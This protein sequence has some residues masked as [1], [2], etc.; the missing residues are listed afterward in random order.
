V[1]TAS[2]PAEALVAADGQP[3]KGGIIATAGG[4]SPGTRP[5][6]LSAS[7]SVISRYLLDLLVVGAAYF[8]LA[9]L[10][11]TLASINPS[12]TPIWPP[13]GLAL[14]AV[15]LRGYRVWPAIFLAAFAANESTAGSVY[16]S[17]AIALGNTFECLVGGYLTR[18]WSEGSGPFDRPLAVARF[19]LIS[20]VA[21]T[22][23]SATIGVASLSL[24][25]YADT[26]RLASIW[27]TWWLGDLAGALVIT[28][29]I[30][31]WIERLRRP[32]DRHL[33]EAAA[34][35]ALAIVIGIVAF[36]PLIPQ[37]AARDPL[38]FL[39]VVPLMWA[40]LRCG[41]RVT[42]MTALL[43][44][45]F[46][47]W[48]TMTGTGPFARGTLNDSFL[49]LLMFI[50]STAVLSLVLSADV[51]VRKASETH[52]RLLAAEL[53]HRV[54]NTLA[55]VQAL[56]ALSLRSNPAP[57]SFGGEFMLRLQALARAQSLLRRG[58]WKGAS[59]EEIVYDA[60]VPYVGAK[61]EK[62]SVSGIGVRL[63]ANAASTLSLAL[64]EL[65]ANAAKHGALAAP[66][67]RVVVT[68]RTDGDSIELRWAEAGGP[69]V[70]PPTRRGLGLELIDRSVSHEFAGD[71]EV[72]FAPRG[73]VCTLRLPLSGKVAL[74][75]PA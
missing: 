15:L 56:A 18:L 14:A 65:A 51:A 61:A 26:S 27:M 10:G 49:L 25:G 58:G 22:P 62:V 38:G 70:R 69:P 46:A 11:L 33:L 34:V 40:A 59:L 4:G 9:K 50:I 21:A 71:V 30:V 60:V 7:A 29:V 63:S 23:I 47:I 20:L 16:T 19:A 37:T 8:A 67:G 52:Q 6:R 36:S 41:Q 13:T 73:F 43:L 74:D 45:C 24:A 5:S 72:D 28:P 48:G 31:L 55:S 53:D 12:A 35:F 3:G 17:A 68:W 64:H 39:A 42:A 57:E 32:L 54:K 66:T 44:C 1:P 2:D 75:T